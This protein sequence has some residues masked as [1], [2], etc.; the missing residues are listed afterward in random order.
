MTKV[1]FDLADTVLTAIIEYGWATSEDGLWNLA[2]ERDAG[3]NERL[4]HVIGFLTALGLIGYNDPDP[5]SLG[6]TVHF[7]TY[8]IT[9]TGIAAQKVG[10]LAY[11][12]TIED[13]LVAQHK[14]NLATAKGYNINLWGIAFLVLG[15]VIS[16]A[17]LYIFYHQV[18]DHHV[19]P[20]VSPHVDGDIRNGEHNIE[21][22]NA[23]SNAQKDTL[24]TG[25]ISVGGEKAKR[26]NSV[27]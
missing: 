1:D 26:L 22:K 17:N 15:L 3:Y 2:G 16:G 11:L 5:Q 4:S 7:G 23:Q 25:P 10:T 6:G 13:H 8:Y 14:A 9:P 19:L 27:K 20:S 24:P 12:Q 21:G 18:F